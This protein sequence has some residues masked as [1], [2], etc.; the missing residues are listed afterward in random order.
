[1][2]LFARIT[3]CCIYHFIAFAFVLPRIPSS[4][5]VSMVA[6]SRDRER[7]IAAH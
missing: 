4:A 3:K 1:M 6:I 7:G 2:A 5:L